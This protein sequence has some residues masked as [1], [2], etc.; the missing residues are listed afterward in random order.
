VRHL[1]DRLAF[2]NLLGVFKGFG[3]ERNRLNLA[4]ASLRYKRSRLVS[5]T[6]G[7]V[8]NA[9]SHNGLLLED[10]AGAVSP[11]GLIF[12][13]VAAT[14]RAI[15]LRSNSAISLAAGTLVDTQALIVAC[16]NLFPLTARYS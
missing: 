1:P 5:I 12:R 8:G 2:C 6:S 10:Q 13:M 4:D 9:K 15:M 16:S 11:N 14:S 7:P 3:R